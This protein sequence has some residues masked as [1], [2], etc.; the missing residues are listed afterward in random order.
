MKKAQQTCGV[1]RYATKC[2]SEHTSPKNVVLNILACRI[3]QDIDRNES[4]KILLEMVRPNLIRLIANARNRVGTLYI[5][6]DNLLAD[7]ESRVIESLISEDGYRIGEGAFLTEYL[8]GTNPKTGW[9]KK[10][11]LWAFSKNQRF[12][13]RHVLTGT[14]LNTDVED[15]EIGADNLLSQ[16]NEDL[17]YTYEP[18]Q[19]DHDT[20]QAIT[21]IIDDGVTLNANEYRVISFCMLHANESNKSRLIDGTHTYLSSIM[22]VSRPRITRLF[23]VSRLKLLRATQKLGISL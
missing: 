11:I 10:W 17:Y 7:L 4:S 13:K 8:F 16:V 15:D 2:Y 18:D 12:H 6:A 23:A 3:R 1:C 19:D 22:R 20:I 14:G 5:D 9:V 21:G